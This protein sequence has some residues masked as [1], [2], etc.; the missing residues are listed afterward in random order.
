MKQSTPVSPLRASQGHNGTGWFVAG[1]LL[2]FLL[3]FGLR[4]YDLEGQ[5]MWSDE[6][7]SLYRARQP[8]SAVL[9]NVIT[10]D[11]V[12]TVDTNP[13]LYFFLL[14]S[15]R[16]LVG[17]SVFL[18][19]YMGVLA[20]VL[21]IPLIY[22]LG[23][24]L[25]STQV[26]VM[27]ALFLALSPFHVWQTQVLRNYGLLITINLFS[28]YGLA[29]YLFAATDLSGRWKWAALWL[30]A[31][32]VGI[33][34]HYFGLFVF[35]FTLVVFAMAV[36]VR[37]RARG[38]AGVGRLLPAL[39]LIL[40]VA[41]PA[42]LTAFA[43]FR[44]GRQ[45]DF[46]D[47]DALSV[48]VQAA[49]A[50][51]VGMSPSLTHAWWLVAPGLFLFVA[52][53]W[54]GCR[55]CRSAT[56]LLLAYQ[57]LPLGLLLALS[58]INPLFNGTRH[59]LIGLPPFLLLAAIMPGAMLQAA[60]AV[61]TNARR[62]VLLLA[63]LFLALQVVWL[64]R[65]FHHPD[66]IRDD[67]RAVAEYLNQ[68]A[69]H[70]DSIV[71]H[72]TLIK[73]TFDYYYEG[74]A[75]V[76]AVPLFARQDETEAIARLQAAG[77]A[78]QKVWFLT[79]P[80]P[81][82]GFP[83]SLLWE[84]AEA[85]WRRLSS[86]NFSWMWLPLRVRAYSVAPERETLPP[87]ATEQHAVFDDGLALHGVTLPDAL[88]SGAPFDVAFYLSQD[89]RAAQDY[90]ISM[91]F[92]DEEGRVWQQVDEGLWPAY[93]PSSWPAERMVRYDHISWLPAGLPPGIYQVWM[94]IVDRQSN[95]PL[96]LNAGDV[97]LR[98]PNVTVNAASC[99]QNRQMA[100]EYVR[101]GDLFGSGLVLQGHTQPAAQYRPGHVLT[102]DVLWCV[103]RLP[104]QEYAMTIQLVDAEGEV[105]A[106]SEGPLT[107]PDY[108]LAAWEADQLLIGKAQLPVPAIT[109][110]GTYQLRL[111]V[112]AADGGSALPVNLGLSGRSLNIGNIEVEA[113][114][115]ET[116][117][118]PIA[119]PLSAAFGEPTLFELHGFDLPVEQVAP[120][121]GVSL[122]FYW[123]SKVD[124][125]SVNYYAFVHV[126]QEG[127]QPEAQADGPP[128]NGF[129]P[130]SSWREGEV[131]VDER[132]LLIPGDAAPG[133]YRL[134]VGL[135]N[136]DTGE[137]LPAFVDGERQSG[138]AVLLRQLII[139]P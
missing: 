1:L 14:H 43:R 119:N 55:R 92:S 111:G 35:A 83:R 104:Q 19:R 74:Q 15:W 114:P 2:I 99:D 53:I 37:Q 31:G 101:D 123:R 106:E 105:V 42:L 36:I 62:V 139:A 90:E 25:F 67:I 69:G 58:A 128:M 137:R 10:V 48:A 61:S 136:P 76:T 68:V 77:D 130:T 89:G 96:S 126:I 98:L 124:A 78:S 17:E 102:L 103:R 131:F 33:Y 118:P 80:E 125:P 117:F 20:G 116:I 45:I 29:R 85:H 107:R 34:T 132:L 27:A 40:A 6:G 63:A 49:G 50:F 64:Q 3:A 110:A 129:R 18:L 39:F 24:A 71:L 66:L 12:D 60:P 121:D 91:R 4:L 113:W 120:G 93:P 94:R 52:G 54:A 87:E 133:D 84:W 11:G 57:L 44:A 38:R 28:V 8:L 16:A 73:F 122:S 47:V 56:L 135:Y 32:V 65:Q 26:A 100:S 115:L 109:P 51:A 59:L 9:D 41:L 138:D 97:D 127:E 112:V 22:I 30:V 21:S 5:S 7:L 88:Q 46:F 75:P 82:T 81:R 134:M 72:D 70:D 86:E 79:H 108:P 95:R 23:R 13:P